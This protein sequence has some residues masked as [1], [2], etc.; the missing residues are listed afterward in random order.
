[1]THFCLQCGKALNLQEL[2]GRLREVCPACGWVYY[3][4]LKVGAGALIVQGG[5]LLLIRRSCAPFQGT[6]NLPAG[7]VEVDESPAQAAER[8]TR[9]ETGLVVQARGLI[10]AYYFDDDPRGNGVLLLYECSMTGGALQLTDESTEARFFAPSEIP[11]PITGA[12][13]NQ[14][15]HDWLQAHPG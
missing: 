3:E 14:A 12:G 8:E 1:M 9:E 10:D 6:W 15:I 13:H 4:E 5:R 11:A 7:Y 2:D